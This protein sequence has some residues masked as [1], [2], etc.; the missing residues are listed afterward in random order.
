M[1]KSGS[2]ICF[3]E[4][5]TSTILWTYLEFPTMPPEVAPNK[6]CITWLFGLKVTLKIT[7]K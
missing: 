2:P 1:F 3:G 6:Y 5:E 7:L 4:R